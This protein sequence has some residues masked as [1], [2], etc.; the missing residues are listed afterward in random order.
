MRSDSTGKT[1]VEL[2][3]ADYGNGI[4]EDS[5]KAHISRQ[6]E[7]PNLF[8]EGSWLPSGRGRILIAQMTNGFSVSHQGER[9]CFTVVIIL[10][11]K[12]KSIIL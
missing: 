5:F 4:D 3:V 1:K 11:E 8:D 10:D 2:R 9:N 7:A 6:I 12:A